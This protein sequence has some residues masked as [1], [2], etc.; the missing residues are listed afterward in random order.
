MKRAL[1]YQFTGGQ[2]CPASDDLVGTRPRQ[3]WLMHHITPGIGWYSKRQCLQPQPEYPL[4]RRVGV[5]LAIST[6][7][8]TQEHRRGAWSSRLDHA[9]D[10][11]A[12]N[13][14]SDFGLNRLPY[15]VDLG[16]GAVA[17]A[18]VPI[19]RGVLGEPNQPEPAGASA[20]DGAAPAVAEEENL[21][22]GRTCK[23]VQPALFLQERRNRTECDIGFAG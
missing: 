18:R 17:R 11:S 3:V 9:L 21:S 12:S 20:D 1:P 4:Y 15:Q 14:L 16:I 10:R 7:S 19:A 23:H 8:K 22:E 2:R 13:S 5:L 6:K